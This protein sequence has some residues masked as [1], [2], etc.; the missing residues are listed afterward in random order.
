MLFWLGYIWRISVIFGKRDIC[1]LQLD[2]SVEGYF[3]SDFFGEVLKVRME[4]VYWRGDLGKWLC[5]FG[6]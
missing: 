2:Y 3:K 5:C 4:S 6:N 1:K